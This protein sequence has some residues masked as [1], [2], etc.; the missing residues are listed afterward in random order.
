[1]RLESVCAIF[2]RQAAD[3]EYLPHGAKRLPTVD[4]RW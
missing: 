3:I 2:A 4:V 1:M